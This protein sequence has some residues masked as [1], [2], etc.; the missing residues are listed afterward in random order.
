MRNGEWRVYRYGK[1][2]RRKAHCVGLEPLNPTYASSLCG[3]GFAADLLDE[4]D[5]A[6]H[7]KVCESVREQQQPRDRQP[8]RGQEA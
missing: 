1:P 5:I 4:S 8:A 7:C 3:M 2:T 6:P